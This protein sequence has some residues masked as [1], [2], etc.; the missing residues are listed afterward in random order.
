MKDAECVESK[1]KTFQIFIFRVMVKIH[2]KSTILSTEL[3]ISPK[4][5]I[6]NIWKLIF[7]SFQYI[8]R[9]S[10]KFDQN[11]LLHICQHST[12]DSKTDLS[13]KPSP[14]PVAG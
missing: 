1:E 2:Q 6:G 3:T 7:H 13:L 12:S 10:F 11:A 14:G 5:K 4:L 9:L 8:P